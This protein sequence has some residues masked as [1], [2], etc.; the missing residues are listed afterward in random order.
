[1]R[2]IEMMEGGRWGVRRAEEAI[3]LKEGGEGVV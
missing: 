3:G 1:M 2:G